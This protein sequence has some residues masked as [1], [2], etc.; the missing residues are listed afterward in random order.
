MASLMS[1]RQYQTRFDLG[2]KRTMMIMSLRVA[3][4]CLAF[5]CAAPR[6][7]VAAAVP[8]CAP[9]VALLTFNNQKVQE[10]AKI[11]LRAA[12]PSCSTHGAEKA[13]GTSL[14]RSMRIEHNGQWI[15]VP[16]SC[17]SGVA[18]RLD[19]LSLSIDDAGLG[20]RIRG[21]SIGNGQEATI[22]IYKIGDQILCGRD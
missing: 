8:W 6:S 4:L 17:I 1:G 22:A 3:V 18:F 11:E 2:D 10:A 13:T 19:E 12:E 15:E 7:A 21:R 14:Q 5:G 9:A 20:V 16:A